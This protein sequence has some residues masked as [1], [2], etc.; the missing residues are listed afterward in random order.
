MKSNI[1][2]LTYR[3]SLFLVSAVFALSIVA[4]PL[5]A[6]A[7]STK[8]KVGKAMLGSTDQQCMERVSNVSESDLQALKTY[9]DK[10]FE[11]RKSLLNKYVT[12]VEDRY[13]SVEKN[14]EVKRKN[15]AKI[16]NSKKLTTYEAASNTTKINKDPLI[17]EVKDTIGQVDNLKGR[18]NNAR[19]VAQAADPLCS[20]VYDQKIFSYFGNKITQQRRID[21]LRISFEENT[22]RLN[23]YR[24]VE[25]R[26]SKNE[27]VLRQIDLAVVKNNEYLAQLNKTQ[28]ALN[29]IKKDTLPAVNQQGHAIK[30]ADYFNTIWGAQGKTSYKEL[31]T[32]SKSQ[33]K[34]VTAIGPKVKTKKPRN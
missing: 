16:A 30:S 5:S 17:K 33:T 18:F 2:T 25:E 34:A 9:G 15:T 3:N 32:N 12:R 31:V 22:V 26:I 27:Q 19:A 14:Q 24:K 21:N 8:T 29:G 7:Q 1:K 10:R 23:N 28:E 4:L 11:K 6:N 20:L 13:K